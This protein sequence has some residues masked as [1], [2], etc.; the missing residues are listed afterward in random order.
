MPTRML[1]ETPHSSYLAHQESE[2]VTLDV[3]NFSLGF[4]TTLD[5][6]TF[7]AQST[8][9]LELCAA[10]LVALLIKRPNN[11]WHTVLLPEKSA[12][13]FQESQSE[14]DTSLTTLVEAAT[15]NSAPAQCH[16]TGFS[17]SI[18]ESSNSDKLV[19]LN[20]V[21]NSGIHY[22]LIVSSDQLLKEVARAQT[23]PAL[24]Q[25]FLSLI[26]YCEDLL[27]KK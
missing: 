21:L 1:Y 14:P 20:I 25:N 5:E 27:K 7:I 3:V 18:I 26:Y 6:E 11:G 16:L 8:R 9:F 10:K 12:I 2:S 23:F 4:G 17:C 19:T 22:L 13:Y 24:Q 15:G